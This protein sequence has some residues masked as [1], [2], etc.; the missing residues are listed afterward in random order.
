MIHLSCFIDFVDK[1]P[2]PVV[3]SV[4]SY[5]HSSLY[6]FDFGTS[7]VEKETPVKETTSCPFTYVSHLQNDLPP[8]SLTSTPTFLL[9]L[10]PSR[11]MV[12]PLLLS[13]SQSFRDNFQRESKNRLRIRH[14][15]IILCDLLDSLLSVTLVSKISNGG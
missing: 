11:R 6:V 1:S 3:S 15:R 13:F 8:L 2:W 14:I 12:F 5:E 10:N 4:S 9:I 7:G